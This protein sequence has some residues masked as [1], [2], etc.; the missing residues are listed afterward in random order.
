MRVRKG[1]IAEPIK[2]LGKSVGASRKRNLK[3]IA[4]KM[5]RRE[6]KKLSK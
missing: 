4:N 6:G 1:K 2:H 5:L 3:R